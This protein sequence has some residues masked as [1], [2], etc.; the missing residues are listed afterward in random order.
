MSE[1]SGRG[2]ACF[3]LHILLQKGGVHND[4]HI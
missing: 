1:E 2:D 4:K 3:E